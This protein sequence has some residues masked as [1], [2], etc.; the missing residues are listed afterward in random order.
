MTIKNIHAKALNED[1]GE[2]F[3]SPKK[4]YSTSHVRKDADSFDQ[5]ALRRKIHSLYE[6]RENLTLDKILVCGYAA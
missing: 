2:Q 1:A 3:S 6:N 4:R 5:E